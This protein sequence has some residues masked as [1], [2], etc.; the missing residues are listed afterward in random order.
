MVKMAVPKFK[1]QQE[2]DLKAMLEEMGIKEIFGKPD[3]SQLIDF[4]HH[5]PKN[6]CFDKIKQK[7]VLACDEE[8]PKLLLQQ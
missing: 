4:E 8:V 1:L 3:V 2:I 6:A 5:K 7:S